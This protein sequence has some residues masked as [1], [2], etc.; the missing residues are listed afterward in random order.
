MTARKTLSKKTRFE[1][2]KRD[3]FKCQYCG[4]EAPRAVLHVDHI[5]PVSKGGDNGLMNLITA[6]VDCNAGKSDRKL[7]DDSAVAKQRTQLEELHE[8]REQMEM[9]LAWRD[10]LKALDQDIEQLIRDKF[11]ECVP[12]FRINEASKLPKDWLRKNELTAI[13]DAIELAAEKYVKQDDDGNVTH[14]SS[15]LVLQKVGGIL[16]ISGL[17]PDK[18]RLYYIRGI[19]RNRLSY[20]APDVLTHMERA[21]EA[22]VLVDD[23]EYAA[24]SERSWSHFRDWLW[25]AIDEAEHE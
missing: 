21:L 5:H 3:G 25:E 20:V 23:I 14:E 22:G 4:A 18:K 2:F 24:K 10:G 13:L 19:L 16:R 9:M 12:G 17:E 6:C 7:S 1:V 15:N 11:R 8:R